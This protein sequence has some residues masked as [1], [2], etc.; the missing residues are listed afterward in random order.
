MYFYT[1]STSDLGQES[2]VIS[3]LKEK[4]NGYYVELGSGDP[5]EGNNTHLL[6]EAF[7]WTGLAIDIDENLADK[8]N[9]ERRNTCI[10]ADALTFDYIKYFEEHN[11]PKVIDYLQ[12]DIDGHEEGRCLLALLALPMLKYK[13][14]IIT[15]EHD[16]CRNFKWQSMRDAQREILHS[17]GYSLTT[18][19][20]GED[21]WVYMD[22]LPLDGEQV[23]FHMRNPY[24]F[25][26]KHI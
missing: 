10:A 1:R 16:L 6:E 26:E 12:I 11:Y 15:I 13:F 4:K 22:E 17:L 8:Y 24:F 9:K 7:N 3:M 5:V 19:L 25:G 23:N 14:R 21:W 18:Q 20:D 2:Y